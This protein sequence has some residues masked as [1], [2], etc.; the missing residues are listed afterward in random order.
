[1]SFF[2][3]TPALFK[4]SAAA[5]CGMFPLTI[6]F[7]FVSP[8]KTTTNKLSTLTS[9]GSGHGT[10]R[11][12]H[13]SRWRRPGNSKGKKRKTN[14]LALALWT[15]LQLLNPQTIIWKR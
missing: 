6:S 14:A 7:H 1:M 11:L 8:K 4:Q 3:D 2:D 10:A 12:R 15:K 5:H 9:V 13:S